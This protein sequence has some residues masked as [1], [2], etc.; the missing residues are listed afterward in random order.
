MQ[1]PACLCHHHISEAQEGEG[2]HGR[3]LQGGG[4]RWGGE[5]RCSGQC[6]I[7]IHAGKLSRTHRGQHS[8][9]ILMRRRPYGSQPAPRA[10]LGGLQ[11]AAAAAA[12]AQAV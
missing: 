2:S 11:V 4:E 6:I 7:H 5:N 9:G 8:T 12:G 1:R 3:Q 10:C